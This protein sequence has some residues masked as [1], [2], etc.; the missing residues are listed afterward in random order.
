M[1]DGREGT[2]ILG[3]DEY[4]IRQ[5]RGQGQEGPGLDKSS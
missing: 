3:E 4:R 5:V 2:G 1:L